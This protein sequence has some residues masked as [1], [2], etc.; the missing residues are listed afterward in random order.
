MCASDQN[1]PGISAI[2]MADHAAVGAVLDM[3]AVLQGL[4]SSDFE[5]LVVGHTTPALSELLAGLRASA[6][7]LPLRH[8]EGCAVAD[9]CDAAAYDLV[10]VAA[11]GGRFDVR[12][13]N[14]FLEAIEDGADVAVGYRP[15]ATDGIVRLLQ[16]LG[17]QVDV[18]CA[19]GLFRRSICR[20]LRRYASSEALLW[21]IRH[22]GL[23]MVEV[24][25][26]NRR[27]VI[28]SPAPAKVRVA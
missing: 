10:F 7:D 3:A 9:G 11:S 13:L 25:L 27:P 15:R 24:P 18:D 16:R 4:V 17:W 19:F 28:G 20:D 26:L 6:P 2:T 22:L 5:I 8:I 12:E 23:R 1:R 14:H 21:R